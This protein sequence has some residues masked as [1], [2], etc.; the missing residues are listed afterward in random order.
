MPR[1]RGASA[2]ARPA[3]DPLLLL[4]LEGSGQN[5]LQENQGPHVLQTMP[6]G[7]WVVCPNTDSEPSHLPCLVPAAG[8]GT[9]TGVPG[10]TGGAG[11]RLWVNPCLRHPGGPLPSL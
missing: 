2:C 10:E 4:P 5:P 6:C 7:D 3:A 1:G 9:V 8:R 11:G